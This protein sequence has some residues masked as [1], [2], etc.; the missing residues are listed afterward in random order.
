MPIGKRGAPDS[1]LY[2]LIAFVGLFIV[3]AALAVIFYLKSE[4]Q[5]GLADAAQ[6][7]LGEVV[8]PAEVQKIGAI[9]GAEQARKS[10]MKA[11]VDYLD[12]TVSLIL[13]VVP[14]ETSAEAKVNEATAKVREMVAAVTK[15]NPDL[16]D[17]DANASLL[18]VTEKLNA[19]LQNTKTSETSTKEQLDTLQN[20]FND[21]MKVSV[22]KEKVLLDEKD[23]Y[24][25]QFEKARTG[26]DELKVL[27]EKKTDE[28][29]KDLYGKLD[30][31]RS[32]RDEINKQLLK[33]QMELHTADDR[34]QR[35]LKEDVWPI[36][37]PPDAEVKAFEPDGKVLLIDAP[38]KIV[39]INLGS[40]D[41]VYRGLTFSV[42]DKDQPIPKDGKGKAE[43]EVY[44][45]GK[46]VSAARIIRVEPKNPIAVDDVVA[47]LIWDAKKSNTFVIAGDFDLNGSGTIDPD[48]V[49]K[50]RK[51]IEKW[52]GVIA[53]AV[54]ANTDFVI[55]GAAPEIPKK[56][57]LE[58]TNAYPNA[59]EKYERATEQLAG[60]KQVQSQAQALSIPILNTE[61]FLYFIGY[62][63]QAGKPGAF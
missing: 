58:E 4:E 6:K 39:H 18:Q 54:S 57:T 41:R 8:S 30:K 10:R 19:A 37:P 60:Y 24:Q 2:A 1:T 31:E 50:L 62:K 53:D 33:T 13:P 32:N 16:N 56:P 23:R 11:M 49:A 42:Y 55:L 26:Y 21:A 51:L 25:Q 17:I 45:V 27:L 12:Q 47:N 22:E 38:G 44:N 46:N 15:L 34:I 9:V 3:A 5:R 7:R 63:T 61:R 20:R 28:Q 52:G 14:A 48:A 40:D 43:I 36:K 35:I 59:M 29:V